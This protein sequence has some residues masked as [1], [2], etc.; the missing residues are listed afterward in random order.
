MNVQRGKP[1]KMNFDVKHRFTA[2][3]TDDTFIWRRRIIFHSLK[4]HSL[5]RYR[6]QTHIFSCYLGVQL[7]TGRGL[8]YLIGLKHENISLAPG[9]MAMQNYERKIPLF[10]AIRT[11]TLSERGKIFNYSPFVSSFSAFR[12]MDASRRLS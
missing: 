6:G 1:A 8:K 9:L 11:L 7:K 2:R 5:S 3:L 4:Y 12:T 10:F